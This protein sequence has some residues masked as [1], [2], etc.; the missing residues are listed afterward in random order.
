MK[1]YLRLVLGLLIAAFFFWLLA[2]NIS[3]HEVKAALQEA[4]I[5]WIFLSAV[6]FFVGYACRIERWRLMLALENSSLRWRQC[7]GPFMASVAANNIFPLRA[8]D[9]LRCFGFNGRLG[10]SVAISLSA[11]LV[12]RLL[13]VFILLILLGI[14]TLAFGLNISVFA[15]FSGMGFIAIGTGIL[16]TLLFPALF[17]PL[18]FGL[19]HAVGVLFP[20]L[21]ELLRAQCNKIFKALE[22]LS[23]TTRMLQLLFWSVLAWLGEGLVFLLVALALPS[24]H[25][26][27]AAWLAFPIGTLATIIP[28]TPGYAGTFDYFTAHAMVLLGNNPAS[29]AAYALL[30]HA[31]LWLPPS[32]AGISSFMLNPVQIKR[33]DTIPLCGTN[34][35]QK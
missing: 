6:V 8:G 1:Q 13:D 21:G 12:E 23:Q 31:V 5:A 30:V 11:L 15:G 20:K 10:I 9:I 19:T 32:L 17:R 2:R 35:Q 16:L 18:I 7:A 3:L 33:S 22:R 4:S 14:A 29:A 27:L 24:L 25:N 28:S 34:K 26:T